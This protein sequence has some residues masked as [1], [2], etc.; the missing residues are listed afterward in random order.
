[1]SYKI[2]ISS[3]AHWELQKEIWVDLRTQL[4]SFI[5]SYTVQSQKLVTRYCGGT[6]SSATPLQVK[7][8]QVQNDAEQDLMSHV[9]IIAAITVYEEMS[10]NDEVVNVEDTTQTPKIRRTGGLKA[11]SKP[12][13]SI[14]NNKVCR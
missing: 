3:S 12:P 11:V 6:D 13:S 4:N 10:E 7:K 8:L 1:M 2:F 14:S 5:L 9:D